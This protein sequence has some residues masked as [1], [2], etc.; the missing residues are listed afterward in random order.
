MTMAI[1]GKVSIELDL[2]VEGTVTN[3]TVVILFGT[4]MTIGGCESG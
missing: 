3:T 2:R 1:T 4:W